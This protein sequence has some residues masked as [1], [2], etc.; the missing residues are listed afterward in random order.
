MQHGR[1]KKQTV[2]TG[3]FAVRQER[4]KDALEVE[5]EIRV[6]V[7]R[8][9]HCDNNEAAVFAVMNCVP[10]ILHGEN[11]IGLKLLTR[12][13]IEGVGNATKKKTYADSNSPVTRVDNFIKAVE[14][15]VN[16]EILGSVESPTQWSVP[17]TED[18]KEIGIICMENGKV[19][20]VI[21]KIEKLIDI[22]I[23]DVER[24]ALWLASVIPYRAA[25]ISLRR[26]EDFELEQAVA[27]QMHFR[28]VR[29]CNAVFYYRV[30]MTLLPH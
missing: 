7:E 20:R 12:L 2:T 5:A 15:I 11:R 24:T 16:T 30:G 14:L 27:V 28:S 6:L 17:M 10:C 13:L 21:D 19:H 18:R 29:G 26:K 4:L 22:A 8:I 23:V 9:D 3:S 1:F 25:M